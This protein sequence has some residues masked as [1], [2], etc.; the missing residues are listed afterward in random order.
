LFILIALAIG[1]LF[2]A[3]LEIQSSLW[4]EIVEIGIIF[5]TYGLAE[6]WTRLN[7]GAFLGN[8]ASKGI[9]EVTEVPPPASLVM[10]PPPYWL[11]YE[12][13]DPSFS[14]N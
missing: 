10:L 12:E 1:L 13:E 7:R 3:H 5:I 2:L 4:R 9:Y 6:V 11:P 14:L 8:V